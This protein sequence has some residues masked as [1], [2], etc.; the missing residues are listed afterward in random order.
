MGQLVMSNELCPNT[1]ITPALGK[2]T[3]N[4]MF[5]W[6]NDDYIPFHLIFPTIATLGHV[7][8]YIRSDGKN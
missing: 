3:D 5:Q 2:E 4:P 7:I 8:P 1:A 6:L